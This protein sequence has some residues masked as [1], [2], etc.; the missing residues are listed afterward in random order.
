M[1]AIL[2]DNDRRTL[3]RE[4]DKMKGNNDARTKDNKQCKKI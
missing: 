2:T 3:Q 1:N 4:N